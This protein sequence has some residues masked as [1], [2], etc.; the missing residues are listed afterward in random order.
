MAFRSMEQRE[1]KK[2]V[3]FEAL[4]GAPTVFLHLDAR[5]DGVRVP[6][7]HRDNPQLV[8][9][10]GYMLSPPINITL[11]EESVSCTLSF[12]RAPFSCDIP[13]DA[14]YAIVRDDGSAAVWPDDIPPEAARIKELVHKAPALVAVQNAKDARPMAAVPSPAK[15]PSSLGAAR[16]ASDAKNVK[17]GVRPKEKEKPKSKPLGAMGVRERLVNVGPAKPTDDAARPRDDTPRETPAPAAER[18][19]KRELPPYLR[20]IK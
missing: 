6:A 10:V 11:G 4:E 15:G 8:L 14:I 17:R 13:W 12:N 18:K 9:R 16:K 1:E 7:S 5:R 2:Q 3:L 19:P 20:V